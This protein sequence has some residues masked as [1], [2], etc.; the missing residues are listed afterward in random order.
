M[1]Q[2]REHIEIHERLTKVET[3]VDNIDENVE[4]ILNNHLPH[5]QAGINKINIRL[6]YYGGGIVIIGWLLN[7]YAK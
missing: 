7:H 2:D 3:R 6:A 5:I 4:K 1:K